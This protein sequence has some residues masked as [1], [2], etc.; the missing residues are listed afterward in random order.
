[1]AVLVLRQ[2]STKHS[3]QGGNIWHASSCCEYGLVSPVKELIT[4]ESVTKKKVSSNSTYYWNTY[5]ANNLLWFLDWI[6]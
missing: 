4:I 3:T 1:V 6:S 2:L 5:N